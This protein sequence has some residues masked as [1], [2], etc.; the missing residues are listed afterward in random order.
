MDFLSILS[1]ANSIEGD[2]LGI[3]YGKAEHIQDIVK[4]L[5]L[6]QIPKRKFTFFDN[7]KYYSYGAAYDYRLDNPISSHK[8]IKG[9][10]SQ[11]DKALSG[12]IGVLVINLDNPTDIE[13]VLDKAFSK[14]KT[15]GMMYIPQYLNNTS[16]TQFVNEY[17]DSKQLYLHSG[18]EDN[19]FIKVGAYA[20]TLQ[21]RITRAGSPKDVKG[22]KPKPKPLSKFEDRYEKQTIPEFKPTPVINKNAKVIGVKVTK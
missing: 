19:I 21:P 10:Y 1:L 2:Y 15:N 22:I 11:I 14:L 17:F 6:E 5:E 16:I 20:S 12:T 9:S 8:V 7:F 4:F 18:R 13:E 3:G